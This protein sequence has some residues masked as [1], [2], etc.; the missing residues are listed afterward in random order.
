MK[1]IIIF[2]AFFIVLS[3]PAFAQQPDLSLIPYR[4]GDLWG[5]ANPW[6]ISSNQTR[7]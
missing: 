2:A 4:Q 7:F 6:Q 1:R 5:Y 3:L